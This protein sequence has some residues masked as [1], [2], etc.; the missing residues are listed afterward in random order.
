MPTHVYKPVHDPPTL[1]DRMLVHP[2]EAIVSLLSLGFGAIVLS[3][4]IIPGFS[5]SPSLQEMPFVI[6]LFEGIFLTLGGGLAF[7]GLQWFGD[8]VSTGWALERFGWL[9]AG[10]GFLTYAISVSWHFPS[11]VLAWV[12]PGTL[13]LGAILRCWVLVLIERHTRLTIAEVNG[14]PGGQ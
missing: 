13:G 8:D 11:S 3:G 12:V 6:V 10:G 2:L 9:L 5:P 14:G 1:W 7:I 4:L